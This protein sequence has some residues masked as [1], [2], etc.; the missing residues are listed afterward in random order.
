MAS[1]FEV[2]FF[3]IGSYEDDFT[4]Q[5]RA[6]AS[7]FEAFATDMS[8]SEMA[9]KI[10]SFAP[11]LVIYPEIGMDQITWLLSLYRLAPVQCVLPG[12]PMTTGNPEIDYFISMADF[13]PEK[14]QQH[15]T[16]SLVCM[17]ASFLSLPLPV[18]HGEPPE[19][20]ALGFPEHKR[21]YLVPATL[22]KIHPD[23][24]RVFGLILQRDPEAVIAFIQV[25]AQHWHEKLQQRFQQTL[26]DA[27]ARLL[28]L[29]WTDQQTFLWRLS[30]ADIVLDT[31]YFG[32][33]T[34]AYQAFGLG[35][36]VITW[37][38][39]WLRARGVYGLYRQMG[40]Q[41]CCAFSP[42]DYVDKACTLALDRR[43]YQAIRAQIIQR[44]PLIFES[45]SGIQALMHFFQT[46]IVSQGLESRK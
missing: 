12:H 18:C 27:A 28:F 10:K 21:I 30:Q 17:P 35:V 41:D 43:Q 3:Q 19:R 15:Y 34:T 23:M 25:Q 20:Q 6:G 24:D 22:F 5:L 40:I 4:R 39:Q 44:S 26:P 29:P 42:E 9:G 16:E 32:L 2:A 46:C 33:G 31:F 38:G 14:A 13:E 1:S 11:D 45:E 37:P 8:I 7:Y 36:P